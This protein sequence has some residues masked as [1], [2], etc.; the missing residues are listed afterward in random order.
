MESLQ[1]QARAKSLPAF[2]LYRKSVL[3][4]TDLNEIARMLEGVLPQYMRANIGARVALSEEALTIMADT[5]LMQQALINLVKNAVEAMPDGGMLSL[6]TGRVHFQGES[7]PDGLNSAGGS[8][9]F[10]S[11]ADT[12]IGID[13]KI[14]ERIFEPL[15]TTKAD[16]GK[17]LGLPTAYH[18]IKE[19]GGSMKVESTPGHGTVIHI[20]MPLS[21]PETVNMIPIPLPAQYDRPHW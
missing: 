3:K 21:K 5:A 4:E 10:L 20:Y 7:L 18:I 9:A 2:S 16:G 17:G 12:G 1:R 8:C 6:R 13:E 11:F 19:H 15:F 14:K